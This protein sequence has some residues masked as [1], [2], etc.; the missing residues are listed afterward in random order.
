LPRVASLP[1]FDRA[2]PQARQAL[3]DCAMNFL[4]SSVSA[5]AV[6]SINGWPIKI[7]KQPALC[8]GEMQGDG[9]GLTT[10]G[11]KP[12]DIVHVS[13]WLVLRWKLL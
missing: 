3:Q 2:A 1:P 13:A 8:L 9:F 10:G 12:P 7:G 11:Q 6:L 5:N 4:F